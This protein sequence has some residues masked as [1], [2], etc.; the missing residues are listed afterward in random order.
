MFQLFIFTFFC[1]QLWLF[2]VQN[3]VDKSVY[4]SALHSGVNPINWVT[5]HWWCIT[6]W[7]ETTCYGLT[8]NKK[9]I[10]NFG[11]IL[12]FFKHNDSFIALTF[13]SLQSSTFFNCPLKP[14]YDDEWKAFYDAPEFR[15][16]LSK[17][18][19]I[20]KVRETIRTFNNATHS[21]DHP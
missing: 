14:T 5:S 21:R 15:K 11:I 6:L 17:V 4:L 13:D 20:S 19:T 1:F 8:L 18:S 10:N 9:P 3:F 2:L 12:I 16:S 7:D